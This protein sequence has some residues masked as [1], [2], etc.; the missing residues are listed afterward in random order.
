[1]LALFALSGA[2]LGEASVSAS[3]DRR[4][5]PLDDEVALTITVQG[6]QDVSSP[7]LPP[8][9]DFTVVSQSSGQSITASAGGMSSTST[10]E[11]VL[12]PRSEGTHT[13]PAIEVPVGRRIL[14]TQPITVR[15][16]PAHGGSRGPTAP[17]EPAPFLQP[18]Q[19]QGDVIVRC[20]IDR[21][22]AYVGQQV[23]LTFSFLYAGPVQ[24]VQYEP[25]KTEGFRTH[26]VT[27]PPPRTEVVKGRNYAVRQDIKA[28]FPTQ[29]GK[30]TIGPAT[31]E[32]SQGF[33]EPVPG[34]ATTKPI[35]VEVLRLP[36]EGKPSGFSGV[37]GYVTVDA[38]LDRATIK[39]GEAATLTAAVTGWGNLDAM[40]APVVTLPAGLRKYRATENREFAV[41][42]YDGTWRME[43][44]ALFDTVIVPTTVGEVTIPPVEV[45]YFDP[46]A[47]RYRVSRSEPLTLRVEPGT[48]GE[49]A[50]VATSGSSQ[51][52]PL[53][54][55]LVAQG[56]GPLL[57]APLALL[58]LGGL[59]W[60][61]GT[62]VVRRRRAVLAANPRLAR[63]RGAA[64]RAAR[65]LRAAG[66]LG[67]REAAAKTAATV[68]QYL[69]EKL[70]VPP[71]TVSAAEVEP[72][73]GSV[74]LSADLRRAV[75]DLLRD[76]DAARFGPV[77][78]SAP[79]AARAGELIRR[80]EAE[81][82]RRPPSA[83]ERGG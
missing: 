16:L 28:L 35:A 78:D 7:V 73:L 51:L 72:L 39:R 10:Y 12:M 13:I 21:K 38:S 42:P 40:R 54:G 20:D 57:S 81:L 64:S 25:P 26:E 47:A 70:D 60:L 31:V 19:G 74:G 8:L 76:C 27:A 2:A 69:A 62:A 11:Y 77:P 34:T 37:V 23:L 24:G 45:S 15:V 48:G 55:R 17:P 36:E 6:G 63:M 18:D 30:L 83:E 44:K 66:G 33:W 56:S 67:P 80:L 4:E 53:P 1:V 82:P 79:V 71:A 43:G 75:A 46:D 65:G 3:V 32:Y 14:K 49:S 22:R 59:A 41:K 5:V 50:D 68:A 29:P 61:V 52:E 9:P 58:Q